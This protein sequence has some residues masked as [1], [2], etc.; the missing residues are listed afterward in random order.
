MTISLSRILPW[1]VVVCL[2]V[3]SWNLKEALDPIGA[4]NAD[5]MDFIRMQASPGLREDLA[6]LDL[7]I[8]RFYQPIKEAVLDVCYGGHFPGGLGAWR[9]LLVVAQIALL[10]RLAC[11]LSSSASTGWLYALS[12]GACIQISP[13]YHPILSYP[14]VGLGLVCFILSLD[15]WLDAIAA[16]SARKR[17]ISL[18][19]WFVACLMHEMFI[20]MIVLHGLL[21][22]RQPA[23]WKQRLGLMMPFAL[24]GMAYTAVYFSLS[25]YGRMHGITYLGVALSPNPAALVKPAAVY[26]LGSLPGIELIV[27]RFSSGIPLRAPDEMKA[28]LCQTLTLGDLLLAA[29]LGL[30]ASV[31]LLRAA[32][33]AGKN[34]LPFAGAT[35]LCAPLPSLLLISSAKYQIWASHRVFPYIYSYYGSF[36][37]ILALVLFAIHW[38]AKDDKQTP[39]RSTLKAGVC[40]VLLVILHLACLAGYREALNQVASGHLIS[41]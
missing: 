24:S 7:G 17:A 39:A 31:L 19:L 14:Q 3:L 41:G 33:S 22:I 13:T 12:L 1:A 38:V 32:R 34:L 35:L 36:F 9:I 28:L 8:G 11:K 26:V 23:S 27:D 18:G 5:D 40:G 30:C 20:I 4:T 21:T 6:I 10:G 2:L 16:G 37:F 29:A 15:V 25:R